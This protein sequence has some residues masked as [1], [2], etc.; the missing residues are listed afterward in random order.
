MTCA[1]PPR[2]EHYHR[3]VCRHPLRSSLAP[4]FLL[5][6]PQLLDPN[7]SR[8]VVLLCKHSEDGAFGLV[9]NRPLVEAGPS[10]A[11]DADR[12][13]RARAAGLG[14]RTGRA[15]AQLDSGRRTTSDNDLRNGDAHRRRSVLCRRRP[16]CCGGLL[17]P[18]AAADA[19]D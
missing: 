15:A 11:S 9:V 8:T 18:D 5:S 1:R 10:D 7:F 4:S 12:R 13:E 16:I 3:K 17:E 14:R 2:V 6:M 19:R